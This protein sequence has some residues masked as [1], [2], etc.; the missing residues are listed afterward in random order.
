M[1]CLDGGWC[2]IIWLEDEVDVDV[3]T[4]PETFFLARCLA[5]EEDVV[6]LGVLLV[7]EEFVKR[8]WLIGDALWWLIDDDTW[9]LIEDTWCCCCCCWLLLGDV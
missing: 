4:V 2:E 1:F 8:L 3:V 6:E 7:V 9:L 5:E